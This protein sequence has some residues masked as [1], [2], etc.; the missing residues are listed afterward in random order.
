MCLGGRDK[1]P[2]WLIGWVVRERGTEAA[3]RAELPGGWRCYS[4]R[5]GGLWREGDG[6]WSSQ[7]SSEESVRHPRGDVCWPL[8][9]EGLGWR[10][11]HSFCPPHSLRLLPRTLP[12]PPAPALG[13]SHGSEL[14]QREWPSGPSWEAGDQGLRE[15]KMKHRLK[16][17]ENVG[18]G[19]GLGH[20]PV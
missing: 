1:R 18:A 17:P 3:S 15:P 16:V 20:P 11:V 8:R 4:L 7:L 12:L 6:Q 10:A 19:R 9:W 2:G 14:S 5:P 13:S